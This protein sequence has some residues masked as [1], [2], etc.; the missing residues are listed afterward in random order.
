LRAL[1]D[2]V[3]VREDIIAMTLMLIDYMLSFLAKRGQWQHQL[4]NQEAVGK[5]E[6]PL[7]EHKFL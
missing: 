3:T 5:R 6:M 1:G 2:G 7:S 4:H